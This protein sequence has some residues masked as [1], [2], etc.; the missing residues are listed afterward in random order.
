M[1]W[2][3]LPLKRYA[4]FTGRSRRME[5]W[6][7]QLGQIIL[8][9]VVGIACFVLAALIGQASEEL[10][11]LIIIFPILLL[12]M[13]LIVPNLAVQVRRLHDQDKSGW[14]ILIGLIPFGGFI[15]LIFM[16]L[17][18]TAGPNQYG[19]DPK[20]TAADTFE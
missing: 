1:E 13:A 12:A 9:S 2:M 19:E 3:L 6:M 10:A 18:G 11:G 14:M 16:F 20:G 4:D 7:F 17:E 8:Y 5:Y 15:L